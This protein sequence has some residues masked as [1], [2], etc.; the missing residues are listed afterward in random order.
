MAEV[1]DLYQYYQECNDCSG[2]SWYIQY[3]HDCKDILQIVCTNPEC[4]RIIENP[5][6]YSETEIS[7]K[8]DFEME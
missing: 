3:T 4:T 6:I 1:V 5:G 2:I 7:F 8:P